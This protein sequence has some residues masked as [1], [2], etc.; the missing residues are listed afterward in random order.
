MKSKK[1]MQTRKT[2]TLKLRTRQIHKINKKLYTRKKRLYIGGK[3]TPTTPTTPATQYFAFTLINRM[4]TLI[5]GLIL[6]ST[7]ELGSLIGVDVSNPQN[8][9]EQLDE[10]KDAVTDPEIQEKVR[11]IASKISI[12]VSIAFEAAE[13]YIEPL[14]DKLNN[15]YVKSTSDLGT[16]TISILKNIAKAI[17][18]YGAIVAIIDAGNTITVTAANTVSA[19]EQAKSAY[20]D[21][22]IAASLNFKDL[23]K[24]KKDL[25][26]RIPTEVTETNPQIKP[27]T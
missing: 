2:Q 18:V 23:L 5:E 13:P 3:T 16:S 25:L 10:I 11:V 27:E 4:L 7:D 12:L 24:E 22:I 9:N 19:K 6:K 20:D 1:K 14:T 15:I 26:S 21:A 17:P 8:I